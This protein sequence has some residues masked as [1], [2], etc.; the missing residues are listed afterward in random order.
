MCVVDTKEEC[1]ETDAERRVLVLV[2]VCSKGSTNGIVSMFKYVK[3]WKNLRQNVSIFRGFNGTESVA[4]PDLWAS[5][6][7]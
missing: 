2:C 5:A 7:S 1:R 3:K 4:N 6:M